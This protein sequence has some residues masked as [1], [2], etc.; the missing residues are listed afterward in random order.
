MSGNPLFISIFSRATSQ[1]LTSILRTQRAPS[2][3]TNPLAELPAPDTHTHAVF[4]GREPGW[5]GCRK[6]RRLW[7]RPG[8]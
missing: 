1:P 3:E 6:R 7:G 2:Q 5:R 4:S 8:F